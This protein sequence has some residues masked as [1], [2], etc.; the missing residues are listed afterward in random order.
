MFHRFICQTSRLLVDLSIVYSPNLTTKGGTHIL[1]N[2][3]TCK[4]SIS[5]FYIF[6]K[7]SKSFI[8]WKQVFQDF[9]LAWFICGSNVL[10]RYLL[11]EKTF[12]Y[13]F[14]LSENSFGRKMFDLPQL[15]ISIVKSQ[16]L[17]INQIAQS[18]TDEKLPVELFFKSIKSITVNKH[19]KNYYE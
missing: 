14:Q 7:K 15:L 4:C 6:I 13:T 10:W 11:V 12:F 8:K 19:L 3:I 2:L 1:H 17:V 18:S 5:F 9:F 16:Y